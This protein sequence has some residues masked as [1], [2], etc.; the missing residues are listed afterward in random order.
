MDFKIVA[1]SGGEKVNPLNPD[2]ALKH[3]FTSLK[4]ALIFPQRGVLERK[5]P[6]NWF[7]NTR[8]L[9]SIFKPH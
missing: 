2:D 4:S 8:Q 7:T 3:H 5:F 6:R 1:L 9:S